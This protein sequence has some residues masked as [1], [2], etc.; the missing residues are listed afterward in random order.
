MRMLNYLINRGGRGLPS[1]RRAE[2]RKAK[3]LLSKRI[4][5][6]KKVQEPTSKAA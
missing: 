4:K 3:A 5:H 6:E 1:E 2:L